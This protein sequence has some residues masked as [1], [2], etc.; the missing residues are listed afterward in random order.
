MLIPQPLP[1][2]LMRTPPPP[3]QCTEAGLAV[4]VKSGVSIQSWDRCFSDGASGN[5]VHRNCDRAGDSS[6]CSTTRWALPTI[7]TCIS[8]K[9]KRSLVPRQLF[10]ERSRKTLSGNENRDEAT[11]M[12]GSYKVKPLVTPQKSGFFFAFPTL[13]SYFL[14]FIRPQWCQLPTVLRVMVALRHASR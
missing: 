2:P 8:E 14:K 10:A 3:F 1:R 7:C 6:C 12:L 11:A 5:F 4:T 9:K 13:C